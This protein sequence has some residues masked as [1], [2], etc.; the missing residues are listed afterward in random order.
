MSHP[1]NSQTFKL[2]VM[3]FN[4]R[5]SITTSDDGPNNWQQRGALNVS[6]I[7]RCTPDLIGLQELQTQDEQDGNLGTY[8]T[9]LP[10]YHYFLGPRYGNEPP[11]AYVT[12]LWNRRRLELV[13]S[14]GFWLSPTPEVYSFGWDATC[15]RCM[16][17]AQFR[18]LASGFVFI[19]ANQ[20]EVS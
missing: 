18:C 19:H 11:Y 12:I 15:V 5:G 1:D 20:K 10:E 7:K 9:Q 17:W 6:V 13:K 8:R 4:I 16:S 3:S 14:G 2:K